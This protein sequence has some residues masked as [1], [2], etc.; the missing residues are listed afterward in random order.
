MIG[1]TVG[2]YRIVD[3]LGRG[4]MGTVYKAV[5]ETLDR[6]VAIKV[7]NPDLTDADVLKRFRA[8][9]V[10]LAR[11][12]H[13]GI[14]T[15]FELHHHNDDLL[16]VMEFVRGET[17]HD[18]SDRLGAI[19]PPQAAHLCMQVLDALGHAHR[20]GVVHRDLKPAN[21]MIAESGAVKVMDFGIARVLGSEHFT[22][23]GYMMGTPA[24][25]APEQ[26]LGREIDGRAD[27]YSVGVV[28]YRLLS[29][30]LPFNADTAISMV[31]M[32]ISEAPAPIVGFK[33][34]LPAWCSRVMERA[35]A[36]APADRFQSAEEFRSTLLAAVTPQALGEMPT[37]ATPT[38]PGTT[39]DPDATLP[40][41][42]PMIARTAGLSGAV[43]GTVPT[44]RTVTTAPSPT[45]TP[46]T[47]PP[48]ERTGT[49]VVLGTTHLAALAAL[50]VVVG[51]GVA[52]LAFAALRRNAA[53]PSDPAA[54]QQAANAST[55]SAAQPPDATP[56]PPATPATTTP[57]TTTPTTTTPAASSPPPA[58]PPTPNTV[59]SKPA[60]TTTTST[61][62]A[63]GSVAATAGAAA[64][65]AGGPPGAKPTG[66]GTPPT[67]SPDPAAGRA[68]NEPKPTAPE[69]PS[70]APVP[71]GTPV[72]T[73]GEVRV[74]IS[75]GER[76]RER[77]GVLQLGAGQ[78]S[79]APNAGA[80]PIVSVPTSALSAVFY[81][82]SKQP[83]WKDASGKD[84]ES[85]IDLGPMGFLRGDRNWIVFLTS[86][87]P[88]ILRIEDSAM[89]TVLPAIEERTGLTIRR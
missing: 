81:S 75:E 7:L 47:I 16:M 23:G 77:E 57:A 79:I 38:P 50:I 80:A 78:V 71:A 74:L 31:Q 66:R 42:T 61:T 10:T 60:P 34:D 2:K 76:A 19:A 14:A 82:R 69:T 64:T 43:S 87:Q 73:F 63:P 29:G 88:L 5:D 72:A 40:H 35:L 30:R 58:T 46:S 18:L 32:Q 26:V 33:P 67:T 15:I 45:P 37:L 24:Y 55:P 68:T 41:R 28:L 84:V 3:K 65:T 56:P 12:S 83:K 51:V 52:I 89:R 62:P 27:L 86:G 53:T 1:T 20:A 4:G 21:L 8:E 13:P 59:A 54:T 85:K 22:H 44:A 6:E 70:T 36:K 48:A 11:L 39:L 49:T 17:F 9:A 25:M